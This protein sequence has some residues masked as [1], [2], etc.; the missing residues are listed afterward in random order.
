MVGLFEAIQVDAGERAG[1]G[2]VLRRA[3]AALGVGRR[4][5]VGGRGRSGEEGE[6]GEEGEGLHREYRVWSMEYGV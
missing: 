2:L 5:V 3:P 6:V 1:F 4:E